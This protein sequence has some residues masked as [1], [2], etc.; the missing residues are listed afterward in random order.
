[1]SNLQIAL[2][3]YVILLEIGGLIGFIKAKS[4]ASIITSTIFAV[5]LLLFVFGVLPMQYYWTVVAV[6]LAFF[7]KRYVA[8]RKFMPA[9]LMVILS[10]IMLV[11]RFV[12]R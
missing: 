6:L 3:V 9:G 4:K 11:L 12:W 10:I 1:M 5:V 2:L 8:G 7:L